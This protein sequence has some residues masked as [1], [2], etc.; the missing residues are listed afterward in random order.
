MFRRFFIASACLAIIACAPKMADVKPAATPVAAPVAPVEPITV[1]RAAYLLVQASVTDRA[2]FGGY[3]GALPPV[4]AKFGGAYVAVAPAPTVERLARPGATQSIV[5]SRWPSLARVKEFWNSS[6]YAQVKT[7]REGTGSFTVVA[8]EAQPDAVL[9]ISND[10]TPGILVIQGDP[11]ALDLQALL[12]QGP[13]VELVRANA[14]QVSV[15][16][17]KWSP[18]AVSLS[19]WTDKAQA[20]S[21]WTAAPLST[22]AQVDLIEGLKL[23]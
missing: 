6:D 18:A 1:P 23:P 21:A 13:A 16:E 5:I 10:A 3:I 2:R 15:L 9:P 7:L 22:S 4:Y 14:A 17:G 11:A 20:R 8:F 12:A 19:L